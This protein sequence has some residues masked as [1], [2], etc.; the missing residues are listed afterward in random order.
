MGRASSEQEGEVSQ[1]ADDFEEP[2]EEEVHNADFRH[3][4][5]LSLGGS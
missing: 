4:T 3:N 1:S 5:G 2:D